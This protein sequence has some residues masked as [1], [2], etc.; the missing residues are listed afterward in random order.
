SAVAYVA[1]DAAEA[2]ALG[3]PLLAEAGDLVRVAADE[4]P[5][6]DDLLAERLAADE[7]EAS[8]RL[9]AVVDAQELAADA[10]VAQCVLGDLDTFEGHVTG[11]DQEAV[12]EGGVD[13]QVQQ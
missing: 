6:H 1:L 5:P 11:I 2:V 12:L 13:R 7:D 4:V 9:T 8:G 10:R 3:L